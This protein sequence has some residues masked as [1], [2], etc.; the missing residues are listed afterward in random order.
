[1]AQEQMEQNWSLSAFVMSTFRSAP[2]M[3]SLG[4]GCII[5]QKS[6]VVEVVMEAFFTVSEE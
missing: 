1:M 4:M 2:E 3:Q 6:T 5:D